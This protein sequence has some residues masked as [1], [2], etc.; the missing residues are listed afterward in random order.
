MHPWI[1]IMHAQDLKG[2]HVLP[3][4]CRAHMQWL[5]PTLHS[6]S[7]SGM[8]AWGMARA[9]SKIL[10]CNRARCITLLRNWPAYPTPRCTTNLAWQPLTRKPLE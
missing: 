10:A 1:V 6:R 4:H 5:G 2:C 7:D 3:P 8:V 9:A